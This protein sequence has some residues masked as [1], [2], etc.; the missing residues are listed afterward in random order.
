MPKNVW[1]EYK[2][3]LSGGWK[4][5]RYEVFDGDGP[6]KKLVKKPHGDSP[7]GRVLLSPNGWL[8]AHMAFPHRMT[9]LKSSPHWQTASDDEIAFV[10][11]GL[12]MYCGYIELFQN[13]GAAPG[14]VWWR[15]KVVIATDPNRIGGEQVRSV[16]YWEED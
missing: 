4:C 10:A 14:E 12:S 11:K 13:E 1:P 16:K 5:I 6:D 3:K 9:P 2:S 15:T 8:S 7:L